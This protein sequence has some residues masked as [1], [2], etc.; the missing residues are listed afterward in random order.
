MSRGNWNAIWTEA[1]FDELARVGVRE[2]CVVPGSRLTPLVL[3]AVRDGRFRMFSILD[4][5]SAG[6][7]ALGIGK[8]SGR[9]AVVITTSGTA[10]ANLYPAIIEA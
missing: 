6:F 7:F 3:A 2:I 1:F 5:R 10:A 8:A 4:E 9:P